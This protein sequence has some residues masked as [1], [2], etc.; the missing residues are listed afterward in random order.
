MLVT[1]EL[2]LA[3]FTCMISTI[4]DIRNKK[5]YNKILVV[6]NIV[7]IILYALFYNQIEICFIKQHIFNVLTTTIIS[8]MFFYFNIWAAGDAKLFITL[9]V[10]IPVQLFERNPISIF[11]SELLLILIFSSAFIYILFETIFLFVKDKSRFEKKESVNKNIKETIANFVLTTSI[12]TLINNILFYLLPDFMSQNV[13]LSLII[14][15]F[16]GISLNEI[17]GKKEII[18]MVTLLLNIV[19]FIVVG[20]KLTWLNVIY[21]LV[22]MITMEFRKVSGKYN[23][24][25]IETDKVQVGMILSLESSM[26]FRNS[27]IKNLPELSTEQTDSRLKV[28]EVDAI[29]RWSKTKRG[30]NHLIIV[31]YIPF[32]PFMLL[33]YLE[34]IMFKVLF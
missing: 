28:E 23:Y 24:K 3:L 7:A 12:L 11:P 2:L 30:I 15:M 29:K 6:T 10:C 8:F 17:K 26:L 22:S 18:T 5:I 13:I 31:K 34:F 4:T 1:F 21:L 33:G 20:I 27:K 19:L 32:A 9:S 14:S 16:I 25:E